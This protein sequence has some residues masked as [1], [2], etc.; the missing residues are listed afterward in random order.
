VNRVLRLVPIS[1]VWKNKV[2]QHGALWRFVRYENG[3]VYR[4]KGRWLMETA[5]PVHA[6]GHSYAKWGMPGVDFTVEEIRK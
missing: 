6:G 4:D 1:K 3:I 5:S 2:A